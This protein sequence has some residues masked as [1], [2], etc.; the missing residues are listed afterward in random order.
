MQGLHYMHCLITALWAI[1]GN[2]PCS[3][4]CRISVAIP[5]GLQDRHSVIMTSMVINMFRTLW[6]L[7]DM[8]GL[9]LLAAA[10][11]ASLEVSMITSNPL[12]CFCVQMVV[13]IWLWLFK[14]ALRREA[15]Q[16]R[17]K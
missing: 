6:M 9:P 2:A 17:S 8:D 3:I 15:H 5:K 16:M 7:F 10:E 13:K 12:Q 14:A 11:A 1:L 4:K